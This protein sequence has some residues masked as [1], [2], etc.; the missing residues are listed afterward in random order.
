MKI[1]F[2]A[3]VF[4]VNNQNCIQKIIEV[5]IEQLFKMNDNRMYIQHKNSFCTLGIFK[6]NT[7]LKK[8]SAL[9]TAETFGTIADRLISDGECEFFREICHAKQTN[10]CAWLT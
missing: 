7:I 3:I 2:Y 9:K 5:K 1:G 8:F 6:C 4:S 10:N